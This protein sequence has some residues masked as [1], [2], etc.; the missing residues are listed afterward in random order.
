MVVKKQVSIEYLRVLATIAVVL[1]HV[2]AGLFNNFSVS[3]LGRGDAAFLYSTY[4]LVSWGVPV[5]LMITGSLLL[6]PKK[7]IDFTKIRTY[8]IRMFAVLLLF[9]GGYSILELI[10]DG[11]PISIQTFLQGYLNML[12]RNS[13]SHMW[14]IYIL[15]SLYLITIPLKAMI[16]GITDREF[17]ILAL[18]LVV[19]NVFITTVN[20]I[21][22][23]QFYGYMQF[24]VF[25]MWFIL[26]YYLVYRVIPKFQLKKSGA[27][28]VILIVTSTLRYFF[29]LHG[30]LGKG[31][32]SPLWFGGGIPEF[33]QSVSLFIL[34]QLICDPESN[35]FPGILRN[36]CRCSFTIYLIHPVFVN[37]FY[38]VFDLTPQKFPICIGIALM[39]ILIF[40]LSWLFANILIKIPALKKIL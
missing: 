38:K 5:F 26:G 6:P 12:E 39:F 1:N 35:Q 28:F 22:G 16:R 3:E 21:F 23:T 17:D 18:T 34:I 24:G 10:F 15:I 27:F 13:W 7:N 4:T 36:L 9:G 25:P 14:Y 29:V 33:I 8:V 19:G 2:C 30:I 31:M 40:G 11:A 37:I 32:V 20:S